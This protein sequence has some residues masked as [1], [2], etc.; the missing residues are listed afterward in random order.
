MTFFV[1]IHMT[2]FNFFPTFI[3]LR[4]HVCSCT[5]SFNPYSRYVVLEF[6]DLSIFMNVLEP[7]TIKWSLLL[8]SFVS[9]RSKL[10]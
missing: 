9:I 8:K 2:V 6:L 10:F 5:K 1:R 3:F 7:K 4:M